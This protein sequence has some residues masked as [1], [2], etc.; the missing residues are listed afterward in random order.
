MQDKDKIK[1]SRICLCG[2]SWKCYVVH[3]HIQKHP[4]IGFFLPIYYLMRLTISL[5]ICYNNFTD[6]KIDINYL[7]LT[8]RKENS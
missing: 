6:I 4:K 3:F 5:N 2:V 1:I 8:N 7:R